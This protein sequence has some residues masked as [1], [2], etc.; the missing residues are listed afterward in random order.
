MKNYEITATAF[1]TIV[2]SAETEEEAL[3]KASCFFD[4]SNFEIDEFTVEE[5][6]TTEKAV[7]DAIRH[8]Y[9]HSADRKKVPYV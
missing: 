6:L 8:S 4:I 9:H 3:E 5:E 2:I 7:A 1:A